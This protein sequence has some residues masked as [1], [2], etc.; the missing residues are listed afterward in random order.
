MIAHH[1]DLFL[2]VGEKLG[3]ALALFLESKAAI[4]IVDHRPVE[5][6]RRVLVDGFDD[7]IGKAREH[8]RKG[9][10]NVHDAARMRA[11]PVHPAM[12]APGRRVGRI[13]AVHGVP[14]VRIQKDEIGRLYA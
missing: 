14:V 3:T 2:R 8:R 13:P 1:H 4:M 9:G 12:K 5:E 7:G 10:M 6:H 11:V